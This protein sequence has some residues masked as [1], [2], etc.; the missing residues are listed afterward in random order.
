MTRVNGRI[1]QRYC[2]WTKAIGAEAVPWNWRITV[3]PPAPC[4]KIFGPFSLACFQ[5]RFEGI[6]AWGA[7]QTYMFVRLNARLVHSAVT[8]A[9]GSVEFRAAKNEV[10]ALVSQNVEVLGD[11]VSC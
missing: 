5:S 8:L 11:P 1:N 7:L 9:T 3:F 10:A 6:A 2:V 4:L